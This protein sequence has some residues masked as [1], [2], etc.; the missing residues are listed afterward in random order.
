MGKSIFTSKMAKL[1]HASKHQLA[2]LQCQSFATKT[3]LKNIATANW[4]KQILKPLQNKTVWQ[5]G[6][7][8]QN[9]LDRFAFS[10]Y[11]LPPIA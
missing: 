7:K 1:H 4:S 2:K 10:L 3:F 5:T 9:N 8:S 6:T 11:T